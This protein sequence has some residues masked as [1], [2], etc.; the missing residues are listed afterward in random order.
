MS[1]LRPVIIKSRTRRYPDEKSE[2]AITE[3]LNINGLFHRWIVKCEPRYIS[4]TLDGKLSFRK[5]AGAEEIAVAIV[6]YEDG[7]IH[8]HYMNEIRFVDGLIKEYAFPEYE[9][10]DLS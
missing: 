8:E 2:G 7:T 6:E 4:Q 9:S 5:I 1:E 10:E 3:P